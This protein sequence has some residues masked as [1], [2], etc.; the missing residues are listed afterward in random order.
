MKQKLRFCKRFFAFVLAFAM[1][2]TTINVQQLNAKAE[3]NAYEATSGTHGATYDAA[4]KQVTF[5]INESD[6]LFTQ[7]QPFMWYKE[8]TSYE[9]AAQNH[10]SNGGEFITGLGAI[11]LEKNETQW[12]H[13]ANVSDGTKAILYYFNDLAGK[14][15]PYYEHIVLIDNTA[16]S[17]SGG[18]SGAGDNGEDGGD[19][20]QT[21]E[22]PAPAAHESEL[23]VGSDWAGASATM[24]EDGAKTII[25]VANYGWNGEWAIQYM[26]KD[27]GY[28]ADTA[29]T[30]EC[31]ITSSID[32]K[33]LIKLDDNNFFSETVELRAGE[34]YHFT[35]E[36]TTGTPSADSPF[37]YFALGKM[38]DEAT[39]LAG[40]MTIENVKM[41]K[42]PVLV[43]LE[44]ADTELY[45]GTDWAGANATVTESGATATFDVTNYGWNGEWGL[46]Y[47]IKSLGY[48]ADSDYTL[49]FDITSSID[50]KV[51]VKFDDTSF[52]TETL[53]LRAGEKY[54]FTK[55]GTTG[56]PSAEKPFLFFALGQMAGEATNLAG[57]LT[58][59]N[60]KFACASG[61]APVDPASGK[62]YDFSATDDNAANDCAD[63]GK[64]K[65]GYDLIWADEF[66]GNYGDANVDSTTGLNLDN[67]AYQ[68]GDGTIDCSNP[69]WGNAELQAYTGN[70]KNIGVNEDLSNNGSGDGLLRITASHEES[71]YVYETESSKNY[72]S[73]RIR[74]TKPNEALFNTTY[75]YVE[76]RISLP[77][78]QGAWPAFWMLPQSTSI[79]GGW[80]ISGEIDI[81]ETTGRNADSACGTLH[82]GAPDHVYKGSGYVTLD[83]EIAY[84]HTYAVDW[85][86]NSMTWYYDGEP[87]YTA[88]NWEAGYATASDKISF[89]AP[90]DQPFYILLNLAVDSGRFGGSANKATFEGDINMYVDYVRV[91]QKTEGYP[92]YAE[93]SASSGAADDWEQYAGQNQIADITA[94]NI[95]DGMGADSETDN[96]K[97]Y[98]STN[99][100]G[101]GGAVAAS[102]VTGDDGSTWAKM[103]ITEAGSQDYAV[104]LIG[105][106]NAKNG[107]VYKVSFDAYADG[108][109]VGKKVNSDSKE[110]VGW[111]AN[112]IQSFDLKATPTKVS[113][114]FEQKEDFDKCRIEF[115]LGSVGTGNVYIGNVKV[116]IVDPASIGGEADSDT[117]T[118][119]SDGNVIYNGTF[120]QGSKH[121]GYWSTL[122]GTTL[123]VPRYTTTKIGAE[124]VSVVDVASKTNYE[125]IADG[126]KY[127]ERRAQIS[128]AGDVNPV[129]YQNG[130]KMPADDYELTFDMYSA[131]DTTVS[132]AIFSTDENGN[133]KDQ[134]KAFSIAY[135]AADGVKSLGQKLNI[136]SDIPN[137]ALVLKFDKGASV[138]VDNVKMIG[139]ELGVKADPEPINQATGW[140][141]SM[142]DGKGDGEGVYEKSG[143][144]HILSNI[145][146]GSEGKWYAPQIVSDNFQLVADKQYELSFKYKLDKFAN[147]TF[148]Y[149][150]QENGGAYR[151]CKVNGNDVT[152]VTPDGAVA[153]ADGFY[154]Y[155][156]KFTANISLDTLHFVFGFGN[157]ECDGNQTFTFKNV[158][159]KLIEAG[160]ES[161]DDNNKEPEKPQPEKPQPEKPQP[162]KPGENKPGN[163]GSS[164]NSGGSSQNV[165]KVEP[166]YYTVVKGDTMGKIARK[167]G[168]TLKELIAMN[169]QIKNPNLIYPGQSICVGQGSTSDSKDELAEGTYYTIVK[170]DCMY[171]IARKH[172]LTLNELYALNPTY[173]NRKYIYAGQKVR[174]K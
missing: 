10:V 133:L 22:P 8:Y 71:G 40:T 118:A 84:F 170:G 82:W 6:A 70:S 19:D 42:A 80:P 132:A 30:L 65:A 113:Y 78:T 136:A 114:V 47:I 110:W 9:E 46:Q 104:Q 14:G 156:V 168:L 73:A 164:N 76:A 64:T 61:S 72:T 26:I 125:K 53:E 77:E 59:E 7:T 85:Q 131:K 141:E 25:E 163:S 129:I 100:N 37:L 17:T 128:A 173:V 66:D 55:S 41:V 16:G 54:H 57:T 120:D 103:N 138:Q 140:S 169:P 116:E 35:K 171:K 109:M 89:D 122:D 50:K 148:K 99:A 159:M 117:R 60:M 87:I 147:N 145:K 123:E 43:N 88:T 108:D 161:G 86:P 75:G 151:F 91:Y 158:S 58:I 160:G 23:Y 81:M 13:T 167:F 154:T 134:I 137:A 155:T 79:Y 36:V 5:W 115:N 12:T 56:T 51:L 63:P 3:E 15:R 83:S 52:F 11:N 93:K 139:A 165:T 142:G 106:Y 121:V 90:F 149:T 126:V 68:L 162:E 38:A 20:P 31:D 98:T 29:Y 62:E 4:S 124:D 101:V 153:D 69:G 95:V 33:I 105:H 2:L 130:F 49:E 166:K 27:L 28:E 74:T 111:S 92:A 18:D 127:Y 97:W 172:K 32:K 119:L 107:Y 21:P 157:S 44:E 39:D 67:W 143:E 135:K 1:V 24:T 144:L 96:S 94:D 48:G 112:G 146:S 150:V 34:K 174:V 45:A 152:E 102:T